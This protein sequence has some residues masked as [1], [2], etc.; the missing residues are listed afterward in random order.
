MGLGKTGLGL[1]RDKMTGYD[2][3]AFILP[4]NKASIKIFEK[5]GYKKIS[6]NWYLNK[7]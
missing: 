4:E 7:G 5:C 3:H 6:E 1:L 2:L